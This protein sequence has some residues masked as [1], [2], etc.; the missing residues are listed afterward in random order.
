MF[1]QAHVYQVA[2]M[3]CTSDFTSTDFTLAESVLFFI[4]TCSSSSL[5][6]DGVLPFDNDRTAGGATVT[7]RRNPYF[8]A[9]AVAYISV[10]EGKSGGFHAAQR[11]C[12]H[13]VIETPLGK[14]NGVNKLITLPCGVRD[15]S[16]LPALI[17]E[18][19][20]LFNALV[21]E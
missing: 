20:E 13:T 19:S 14:D 17:Q 10:K 6:L 2:E 1:K 9:Q 18:Q 12:S 16:E 3:V 4:S 5:L 21:L 8:S 15:L 7:K 11:C